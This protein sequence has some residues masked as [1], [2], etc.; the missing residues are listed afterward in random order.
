ME[1]LI[2]QLLDSIERASKI[3]KVWTEKQIVAGIQMFNSTKVESNVSMRYSDEYSQKNWNWA[4]TP[5]L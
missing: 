1:N 5:N 4:Y 2:Q 3:D